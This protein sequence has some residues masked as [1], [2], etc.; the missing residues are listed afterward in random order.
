MSEILNLVKQH[1][2]IITTSTIIKAGFSRGNL[3]YLI[4][5][6]RLERTSRGV[7]TLPDV[8]EDEFI[9]LQN[10]YKRGIFSLNTALFLCDLTDRTPLQY[11]MTFP[12][13]YNLTNPKKDNILCSSIKKTLYHMGITTLITPSGNKVKAYNAE[14]TLC[15]ILRPKNHVDIQIIT[16]AFKKYINGKEKNI[17]LLSQYAKELK[18]SKQLQAYLEILL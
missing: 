18:V 14:R 1:N 16:N 10:K 11:Q 2:G 13:T 17:P 12:S 15:D 4:N 6:G 9:N 8:W 3:T 7:Y 5:S